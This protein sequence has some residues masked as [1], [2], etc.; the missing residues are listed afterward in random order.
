MRETAWPGLH[1]LNRSW[2]LARHSSPLRRQCPS[3][4]AHRSWLP[5]MRCRQR[6][7]G[8]EELRGSICTSP[9]SQADHQNDK[10]IGAYH[11]EIKPIQRNCMHSS[12]L[13]LAKCPDDCASQA[14]KVGCSCLQV[15][16]EWNPTDGFRARRLF[17]R[18]QKE[19]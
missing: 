18:Q 5:R 19:S 2:S 1:P 6:L 17:R 15:S 7:T 3:L 12:V 9:Q 4:P 14:R 10:E 8:V 11:D 13:L 16:M